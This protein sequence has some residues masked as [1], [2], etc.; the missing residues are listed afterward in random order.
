MAN[1][2]A[3]GLLML[4]VSTLSMPQT[5][6]T[7]DN[8][9][10]SIGNGRWEWTVFIKGD[11]DTLSKVR[12][13]EYLLHPTFPDRDRKICDRGSTPGQAYPLTATGWGTFTIP[14]TVF[15]SDRNSQSLTHTL[16]FDS[17]AVAATGSPPGCKVA[18][19]F[20]MREHDIQAIGSDWPGVYLYAQ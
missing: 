17:P 12:C 4:F 8:T 3:L 9:S 18:N 6:V 15:F 7:T 13:V 20:S 16:R 10:K 5:G 11:P 1:R 2:L 14:V 19:S